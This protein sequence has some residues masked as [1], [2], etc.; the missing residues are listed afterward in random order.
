MTSTSLWRS[1][2]AGERRVMEREGKIAW[3]S[4]MG[5][6]TREGQQRQEKI[7]IASLERIRK[8]CIRG[9]MSQSQ[10]DPPAVPVNGSSFAGWEHR[11]AV[12]LL[13]LACTQYFL[14]RR[15]IGAVAGSSFLP[16]AEE[17]S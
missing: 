7:E 16:A 2:D 11:G 4:D 12:T 10:R 6:G 1:P 3:S 14:I 8:G 15:R 17:P 9:A 5:M 13:A